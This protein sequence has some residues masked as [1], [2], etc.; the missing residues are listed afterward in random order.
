[1]RKITV[2]LLTLCLALAGLAG[3]A[4]AAEVKF[5]HV[6]PPFHGQ[7]QGVD[8]FAAYVKDKTGGAV[9]IKTFPFG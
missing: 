6:A 4:S 3:V 8:A 7:A 1:M 9:V 5:G 2:V